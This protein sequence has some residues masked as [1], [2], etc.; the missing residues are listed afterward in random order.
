MDLSYIISISDGDM[1]FI[2][3]FLSTFEKSTIPQINQLQTALEHRD[4]DTARKLAHQIKPT[5]EL[6]KFENHPIILTVNNTPEK[7]DP[8]DIHLVRDEALR[9]VELIKSRFGLN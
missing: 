9:A 3:D 5:T 4:F 6:L 8:L 7:G 2:V 1:E